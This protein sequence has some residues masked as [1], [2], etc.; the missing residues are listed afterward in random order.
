MN[1]THV[2]MLSQGCSCQKTNKSL[3]SF[4]RFPISMA[5]VFSLSVL[6]GYGLL[7][8][9]L[10]R[11]RLSSSLAEVLFSIFVLLPRAWERLHLFVAWVQKYISVGCAIMRAGARS[12][13]KLFL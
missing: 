13:K 1:Q 11:A 3:V 2:I 10:S 12:S 9:V 5:D 7:L 4:H 8:Y 6:C